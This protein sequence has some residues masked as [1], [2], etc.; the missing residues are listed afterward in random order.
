M[1]KW[2]TEVRSVKGPGE[3]SRG[4]PCG[5]DAQGDESYSNQRQR[6]FL[7]G[8]EAIGVWIDLRDLP[9]QP[10]SLLP[11]G[12]FCGHVGL[13]MPQNCFLSQELMP[14]PLITLLPSP[15]AHF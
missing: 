5:A 7:E 1:G 4:Q 8:L 11:E 13:V 9:P 10:A 3:V 2:V 15:I 12:C 6:G 14:N